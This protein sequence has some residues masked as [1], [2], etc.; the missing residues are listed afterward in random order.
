METVQNC[1]VQDQRLDNGTCSK[2]FTTN[3]TDLLVHI[4]NTQMIHFCTVGSRERGRKKKG[5]NCSSVSGID[6][7]RF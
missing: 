4:M 3:T 2:C 5:I 6:K 1:T 7:T